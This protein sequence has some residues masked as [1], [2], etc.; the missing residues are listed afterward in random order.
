MFGSI[1]EQ[2]VIILV[3]VSGS[4]VTSIDELKKELAV[5]IWEQLHANN[6][7]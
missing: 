1:I 4:M 3:D 2:N 7:K 6:I 5:I